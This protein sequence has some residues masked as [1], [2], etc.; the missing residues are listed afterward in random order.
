MFAA[1]DQT[2]RQATRRHARDHRW[3]GAPGRTTKV[4]ACDPPIVQFSDPLAR[5]LLQIL[6]FAE[7]N[8]IGRARFGAGRLLA[9]FEATATQRAFVRLALEGVD[10]DEAERAGGTQHAQLLQMSC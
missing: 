5:P 4:G 3:P 1:S 9:A 2:P 6:Y 10:I 7:L 8:R